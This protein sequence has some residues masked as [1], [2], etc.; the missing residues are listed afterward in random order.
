M[1]TV[2]VIF[3]FFFICFNWA[4]PP[5][6]NN[7]VLIIYKLCMRGEG[8][9]TPNTNT[10]CCSWSLN[11][12]W[13]KT[14][15]FVKWWLLKRETK[16]IL[17]SRFSCSLRIQIASGHLQCCTRCFLQLCDNQKVRER[18]RGRT[19]EAAFLQKQEKKKTLQL[20]LAGFTAAQPTDSSCHT[21]VTLMCSVTRHSWQLS[22]FS[23]RGERVEKIT[24]T[25]GKV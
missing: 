3:S 1:F 24:S 14:R 21:P 9:T 11:L 16:K 8:C 7:N 25:S 5:S 13:G 2:I 12:F 17:R 19:K 6:C 4:P 15:K 22:V 10:N 23:C 18:K 20:S